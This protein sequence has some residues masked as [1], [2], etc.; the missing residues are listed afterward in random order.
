[1]TKVFGGYAGLEFPVIFYE[2]INEL[3]KI[4]PKIL[5][6]KLLIVN[7]TDFVCFKESK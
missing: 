3:Q 1:M 5:W 6:F 2:L 7:C 4:Q